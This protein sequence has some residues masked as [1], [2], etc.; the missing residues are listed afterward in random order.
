MKE[1]RKGREKWHLQCLWTPH[2]LLALTRFSTLQCC[3]SY[4]E[5]A[6]Y[7]PFK[8]EAGDISC[9]PAGSQLHLD[10]SCGCPAALATHR[11][12]PNTMCQTVLAGRLQMTK[13]GIGQPPST[14][15][16]K[17][18]TRSCTSRPSHEGKDSSSR[19]RKET[20]RERLNCMSVSDK[21]TGIHHW[22]AGKALA[23]Q[24]ERRAALAKHATLSTKTKILKLDLDVTPCSHELQD[25][26]EMKIAQN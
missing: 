4:W 13:H 18:G 5:K 21:V 10:D 16:V 7:I 24:P 12:W 26:K 25:K 22:N 9:D 19:E 2:Q 14:G 11:T 20:R 8:D 15:T 6:C 3:L 23:I 1:G 17:H